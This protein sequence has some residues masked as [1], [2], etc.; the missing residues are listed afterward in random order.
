LSSKTANSSKEKR[1]TF[2]G[3]WSTPMSWDQVKAK[4][5]RLNDRRLEKGLRAE[6]AAAAQNIN[7]IPVKDL[8]KLFGRVSP[9]S[10]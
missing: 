1:A 8:T 6:L 3:F 9:L 4:F 2:D 7:T 5:E 10:V